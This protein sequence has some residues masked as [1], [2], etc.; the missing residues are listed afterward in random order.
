MEMASRALRCLANAGV[1]VLMFSQSF[2]ERSLNLVVR[3]QDQKHS[4][5]ALKK[6]FDRD[7]AL[8]LF[9]HIGTQEEVASI[10][11]VGMSNDPDAAIAPRAFAALGKLG[12]RVIAVAQP[13][14]AHSISFVISERDL[15]RAVPFIHRELG[16]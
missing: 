12:L 13:A 4:V 1:G 7:L 11:V 9:S 8:G 2:S 10:S 15:G 14:S 5:N 6:E 16:L 3:R